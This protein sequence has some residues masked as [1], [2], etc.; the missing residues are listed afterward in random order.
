MTMEYIFKNSTQLE[1][2]FLVENTI[3]QVGR[4]LARVSVQGTYSTSGP[5]FNLDVDK[6]TLA[7]VIQEFEL[8][9]E[10]AEDVPQSMIPLFKEQLQKQL[11]TSA[12]SIFAPFDGSSMI[13]GLNEE[14]GLLSFIIGDEN[15]SME[16][17]F[18]RQ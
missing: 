9:S 8:A 4:C 14:L 13:Y 11:E 3:P 6:N 16:I 1:M 12:A 18:T 17:V 10:M 2:A 15:E 7:V 5:I